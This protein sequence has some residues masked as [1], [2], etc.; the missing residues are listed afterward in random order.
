MVVGN[1]I[2][3]NVINLVFVIPI[4]GFFELLFTSTDGAKL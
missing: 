1:I 4:I 2:G 3:S